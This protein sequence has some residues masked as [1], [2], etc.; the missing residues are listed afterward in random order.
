MMAGAFGGLTDGEGVGVEGF[1]LT[2]TETA[3]DV[4]FNPRV[5]VARAVRLYV[6][7]VDG[8]HVPL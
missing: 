6:P 2:T 8:V 7:A 1:G 5:S 3:D 4:V